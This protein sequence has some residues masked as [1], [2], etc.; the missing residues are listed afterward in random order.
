VGATPHTPR[1]QFRRLRRSD[2]D[3]LFVLDGDPEVMRYL[4][5]GR[6]RSREYVAD[7]VLPEFL[8]ERWP[9]DQVGRWAGELKSDGRFVGRFSLRPVTPGSGPI[10]SWHDSDDLAVLALGYRVVR[11]L[12][13]HGYAT[14]GARALVAHAFSI[15]DV[16]EVV[17]TTMAVN[18]GSRRVMEKAGLRYLRTQHIDWPEP[19]PG[20]EH[21]DVEYAITRAEW[22]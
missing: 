1:L 11:S 18:A 17:S 22:R 13:G 16:D 6:P 5:E 9:S 8:T 10:E 14:E 2:V 15:D 4:D 7:V 19:L 12:W 21:G 20:N 3:N